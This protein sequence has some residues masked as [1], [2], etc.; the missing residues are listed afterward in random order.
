MTAPVTPPPTAIL[1]IT[2]PDRQG[3]VARTS[4]FVSEHRGNIVHA[5]FHVDPATGLFLMRLE[6]SLQGFD[7]PRAEIG[8]AFDPVAVA[9]DARWQLH[10]SDE[11][12]RV[13]VWVTRQEHCLVDLAM[14]TRAGELP[15]DIVVVMA[16]RPDLGPLVEQLALPFV[17]IPVTA[18]G[19]HGAEQLRLLEERRVD[20]VVLAKYMRVIDAATLGRLPPAINIHHSFLP[21]FAGAEPYRQAYERGV[22]II[23]ATAHYVTADLDQGPIIEQD[24]VRVSHRDAVADLVRKGR[25]LERVVLA[26]A[27]RMH[28]TRRVM[29]C[30]NRT[31]VFD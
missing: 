22:K 31:S 2:C 9:I 1:Q 11:R 5:D 15:V 14:R 6:W 30:G 4:A 16:S 3:L 20:L 13:A 26:R 12:P 29:V 21:A 17:H 10:F 7:I 24:I 28:V 18:D 23:G 25:D 27:V 19:Q 8:A